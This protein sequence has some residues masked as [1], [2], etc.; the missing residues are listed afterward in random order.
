[1]KTAISI[2]AKTFQAAEVL[3]QRMGITRSELYSSAI[4]EYIKDHTNHGVTEKL[5][6]V[7]G[8][9][10][11]SLEKGYYSLQTHTL[12]GDDWW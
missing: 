8:S 6:Q 7:Y 5:N 10:T 9:E 3:A 1:M 12:Q 2:P 4:S 11:N